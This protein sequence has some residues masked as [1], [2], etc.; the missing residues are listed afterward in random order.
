MGENDN[1]LKIWPN[2]FAAAKKHFMF[3]YNVANYLKT[4]SKINF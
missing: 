3:F 4:F 1:F 2:I